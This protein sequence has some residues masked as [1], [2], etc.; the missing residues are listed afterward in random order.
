MS[1]EENGKK[2][3]QA[4]YDKLAQDWR[5]IN[6]MIWAVPTVAISIMTGILIGTYGHLNGLPRVLSLGL[7][8]L[9]LFALTIELVKKRLL[10]NAISASLHDLEAKLKLTPFPYSTP[11]LIKHMSGIENN[12]DER[13]P[14]YRIFKWAYA[15]EYLTIVTFVAAV[16]LA[17]LSWYEFYNY[18]TAYN[19]YQPWNYLIGTI[20]VITVLSCVVGYRLHLK[21]KQGKEIKTKS[22]K[23][24]PDISIDLKETISRGSYQD[25]SIIV[26]RTKLQ[27]EIISY[28]R[29]SGEV[30]NEKERSFKKLEA[31]VTDKEGHLSY[32]WKV[33]KTGD[34]TVKIKA[35]EPNNPNPAENC[36][37]FTVT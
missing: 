32:S 30:L 27:R 21:R 7:G 14:I 34:Y 35:F 19:S 8:S 15:R 18:Y 4:Q 10:M 16:S 5:H 20:T 2:A 6:T 17:I 1:K 29:V 13:D 37:L 3:T 9:L 33:D 23:P 12:P 31:G 25:I 11:G 28:A 22:C 24:K 36:R 26:S